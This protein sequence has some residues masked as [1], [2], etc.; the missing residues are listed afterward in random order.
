MKVSVHKSE[1]KGKVRAPS[2]KS[3]AIRGLMCAALAKG[4]SQIINPLSSDDTDAALNV[5]RQVGVQV[6][7]KADLWS[8]TGGSF[9]Q[10]G[11]LN[12]IDAHPFQA[13][14]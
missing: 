5:L 7:Q 2:S 9:H 10:S 6:Q 1:V 8:V 3:Y 4:E 11:S 13:L 12:N 14:P